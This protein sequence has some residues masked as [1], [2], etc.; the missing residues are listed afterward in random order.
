FYRIAERTADHNA[1]KNG[2]GDYIIA[3]KRFLLDQAEISQ[4]YKKRLKSLYLSPDE[5]IDMIN[6]HQS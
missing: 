2:M 5:I 1:V 6:E 3:T 4:R